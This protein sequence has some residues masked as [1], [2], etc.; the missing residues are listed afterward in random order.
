[1]TKYAEKY[2][3]VIEIPEMDEAQEMIVRAWM[4]EGELRYRDYLLSVLGRVK[5]LLEQDE[6]VPA[7]I[8][9]DSLISIVESTDNDY[10]R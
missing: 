8:T 9:L 5:K 4:R 7:K 1:M 2:N 6:K 10:D 3:R